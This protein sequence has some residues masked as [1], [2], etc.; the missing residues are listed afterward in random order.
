MH[1][2]LEYGFSVNHKSKS[3]SF[4]T[5]KK[6][7]TSPLKTSTGKANSQCHLLRI[8]CVNTDK[9]SG[10]NAATV[11]LSRVNRFLLFEDSSLVII[12]TP[13]RAVRLRNRGSVLVRGKRLPLKASR[14]ALGPT[15]APV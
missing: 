8:I 15:R 10:Q 11:T 5:G 12:A 3:S 4:L 6:N 14:S 2:V 13:P 7:L 1:N 9:V